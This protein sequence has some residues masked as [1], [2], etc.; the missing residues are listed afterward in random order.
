MA[1]ILLKEVKIIKKRIDT[2]LIV[3]EKDLKLKG[4]Y[5]GER[6]R[7]DKK[8]IYDVILNQVTKAI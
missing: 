6:Y 2:M 3:I 5:S 4:L 1:T 8:K 7:W